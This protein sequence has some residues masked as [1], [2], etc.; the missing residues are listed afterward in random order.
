MSSISDLALN[1]ADQTLFCLL[2]N[3]GGRRE[4]TIFDVSI[5]KDFETFQVT[6]AVISK[7]GKKSQ[8]GQLERKVSCQK[9]VYIIHLMV[10]VASQYVSQ[11][12][13]DSFTH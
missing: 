10:S 5:Q 12:N 7:G 6:N 1:Y 8:E 2:E 9:Y 4:L 3:G 11:D 13:F